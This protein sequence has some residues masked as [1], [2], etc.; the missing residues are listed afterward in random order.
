MSRA[1]SEG[2]PLRRPGWL[3]TTGISLMPPLAAPQ[4]QEGGR[5]A[6]EEQDYSR[7][8]LRC[9]RLQGWQI[10][11]A[12]EKRVTQ[13]GRSIYLFFSCCIRVRPFQ[14]VTLTHQKSRSDRRLTKSWLAEDRGHQF[15]EWS[16][17]VLQQKKSNGPKKHFSL[18]QQYKHKH[19]N[20]VWTSCDLKYNSFIVDFSFMAILQND[21]I[22]KIIRKEFIPSLMSPHF[23]QDRKS[24]V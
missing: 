4:N 23:M 21:H 24:V 6:R 17:E 1:N 12:T 20:N 11:T 22:Q 14:D 2:R 15:F 3:L 5:E 10:D 16:L 7:G 18:R 13:H 8:L 19:L 9:C